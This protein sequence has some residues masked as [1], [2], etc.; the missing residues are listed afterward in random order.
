MPGV[1]TL[2]VWYP[3]WPVVAAGHPPEVPVAVVSANRVV[4][5]SS[6]A[7]QD[8]VSQGLRR[9]EA[10]GR[11]PELVV[12]SADPSRDLRAWEPAVLAVESL[13]PLV[14]VTRAGIV[15]VATRGPSRYFGGDRALAELVARAVDSAV[16]AAGWRGSGARVGVAD[17]RFAAEL[18]AHATPVGAR[19]EDLRATVVTPGTSAAWL[20]PFPASALGRPD[21][22]DLWA[23]LG[24]RTLGEVAALDPRAVLARFGEEGIEAH[25]LARG[26][27]ERPPA[28]RVPP[29]DL[30]VSAELD[31]PAERVDTVAF[32]ARALADELHEELGALGLSCTRISIEGETDHGERLQRFW[33]HDG[34]LTAGAVAERVRWQLDEWLRSKS[35]GVGASGG[36]ILLRL[37]PDEVRADHGRQLG[38]WGGSAL[39]DAGVARALARVQ[40]MLGP[41]GVV[42]AV[43]G[44]GRDPAEQVH[45]VP[46]GDERTQTHPLGSTELPPWPG[47]LPGLAPATVHCPALPAEVRDRGGDMVA[48]TGRG[49]ISAPPATVSIA[50][51][52]G[53]EVTSW[54]GP[55]PVEE[56]WW[57]DRARRRARLQ[58]VLADGSARL[59]SR[60]GGRWGV[61]ATY[62]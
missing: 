48:V 25:R 51:G 16:V 46:W 45:L 30:A 6:A 13:T 11:C 32:V 33:R 36:L 28:A 38:F 60:E 50:G 14:E 39:G 17:G 15:A 40:G 62:D 37:R 44:G 47:R 7:R 20:A 12:V 42:T 52:R 21:L 57:D 2:V 29:P 49:A 59:L 27:D 24:L 55:W 10:Q 61:D 34:T 41:H 35:E 18:A 4:A 58:M 8:G 9:R 3:D 19:P 23:R 1:R 26:L 43:V 54:A 5:C 31:P 53:L 22:T 56:R